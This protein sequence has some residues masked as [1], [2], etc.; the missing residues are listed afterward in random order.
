[1][2]SCAAAISQ[3]Q[4]MTKQGLR[5][6]DGWTLAKPSEYQRVAPFPKSVPR[7]GSRASAAKAPRKPITPIRRTMSGDIME[8][9]SIT[10]MPTPP[11]KACRVT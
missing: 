9:T 6:S 2:I 4:M 11:K 8:I 1:M 3:A 5:N 7:T 10:T